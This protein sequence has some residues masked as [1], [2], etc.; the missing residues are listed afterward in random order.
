M[1]KEV[2]GDRVVLVREEAEAEELEVDLV[3]V[4]E[5]EEEWAEEE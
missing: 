5:A 1:A 3:L 2:A 4:V